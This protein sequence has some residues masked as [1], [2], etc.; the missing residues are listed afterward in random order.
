[1]VSCALSSVLPFRS[2]YMAPLLPALSLPQAGL[3]Q[4]ARHH[5]HARERSSGRRV[6]QAIP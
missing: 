6:R 2:A 5:N 3:G 1:M 4:Q